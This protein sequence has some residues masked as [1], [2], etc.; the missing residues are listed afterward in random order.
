MYIFSYEWKQIKKGRQFFD[1]LYALQ[2]VNW[3]FNL[4][5]IFM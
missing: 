3:L 5:Q 2:T 4:C 1:K